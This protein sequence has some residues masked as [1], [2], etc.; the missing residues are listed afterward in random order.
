[1]DSPVVS[2]GWDLYKQLLTSKELVNYAAGAF[3]SPL[4]VYLALVLILQ[5]AG[6]FEL[7]RRLCSTHDISRIGFWAL[8]SMNTIP[9]PGST[10]RTLHC[11][12]IAAAAA[13]SVSGWAA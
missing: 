5:G 1:M 11:C 2:F 12:S 13:V 10:S 3:I 7:S 4:S 9:A 8:E 6:G